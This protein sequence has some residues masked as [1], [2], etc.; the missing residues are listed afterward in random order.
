VTEQR[1]TLVP[2]RRSKKPS[3]PKRAYLK[4]WQALAKKRAH[5]TVEAHEVVIE[6]MLRAKYPQPDKISKLK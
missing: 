1:A 3:P 4:A 5:R 6:A 2:P